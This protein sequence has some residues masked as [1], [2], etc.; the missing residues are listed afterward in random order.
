MEE[1]GCTR[2]KYNRQK[3]LYVLQYFSFFSS[4]VGQ[5]AFIYILQIN[6]REESLVLNAERQL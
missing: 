4:I 5:W 1:S 3:R 2:L 6:H